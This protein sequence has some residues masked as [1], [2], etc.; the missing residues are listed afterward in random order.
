MNS[1]RADIS[2]I[3]PILNEAPELP[4][5][6]ASLAAQE[7]VRLELILSD[8][9][10][11]DGSQQVVAEHSAECGFPVRLIQTARGRG[12][13][14]NAGAAIATSKLL[15]FLHA[16]SRFDD[17]AAVSKSVDFYRF[18]GASRSRL[19]AARFGIQFRRSEQS[20]S[21]AWFFYEA[22]ARLPIGDCIRG[23]Q[24]FLLDNRTLSHAGGFEESLPF[25]EDIRLVETLGAE[26]EW[27]LLPATISTSA[28]RFEREGV[29]RRQVLNAIIVNSVATGWTEFF[30][31]LPGIYHCH[32]E[33]GRLLLSPLLEGI[34]K[35]IAGHDRAWQRL[36]WQGTG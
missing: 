14:M 26:V 27:Q 2:I 22:K 28:R 4:G 21:L 19:F 5:L 9:G 6:L 29:L 18:K 35:L 15:L 23:D 13:Q 24:G 12:L 36:F 11:S 31:A 10:S 8:G 33:S 1:N 30:H 16:D 25:L 7:N 3:V 17:S 32:T 20:T 34:G